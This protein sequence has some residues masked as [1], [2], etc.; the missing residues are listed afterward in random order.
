MVDV[1]AAKRELRAAAL[2]R[3]ATLSPEVLRFGEIDIC[4]VA[5]TEALPPASATVAAYVSLPGEPATGEL[6]T[7]LGVAGHRVLL[8][9]LRADLDLDWAEHTGPLRDGLRGTREPSG[10]PLGLEA[11]GAA[12]VVLVPGLLA[13]RDGTRLGRGGGSYD[14]ALARRSPSALVAMLCWPHEI[15]DAL[16]TLPH[17]AR[18]DA[19]LTPDG[20]VRLGGA[21]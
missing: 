9:I 11:I 17:D 16:P 3:R 7:A 13:G 2:A 21:A 18:V 12:D 1:D 10:A 15:V 5:L 19:A 14:R 6:L 4:R 20:L 8:P